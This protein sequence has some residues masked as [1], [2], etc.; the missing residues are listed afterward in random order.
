MRPGNSARARWGPWT[1]AP[2]R[3]APRQVRPPP[4][5]VCEHGSD[6]TGA[7]RLHAHRSPVRALHRRA[8]RRTLPRCA[9]PLGCHAAGFRV[10]FRTG[11]DDRAGRPRHGRPALPGGAGRPR[12]DRAGPG[13][14]AVRGAP[15]GVRPRPPDLV[16]LRG[17]E[18]GRPRHGRGRLHGAARRRTARRR[19]GGGRRP[20]RPHG[21]GPLR[22]DRRLRHARP[23]HRLLPVRAAGAGQ[24]RR[25]LLRV[26]H[27]RG[28]ARHRGVRRRARR[29]ARWSAA[30]CSGWRRRAR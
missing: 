1:T 7:R 14:R 15:P 24:G 29:P 22:P 23:G 17:R 21:H 5:E 20:R 18:P 8:S 27:D 12:G 9:A 26:P 19:P 16:L 11:G 3:P 2:P 6:R 4:T 25:G 13:G 28:P 30:G 10:R